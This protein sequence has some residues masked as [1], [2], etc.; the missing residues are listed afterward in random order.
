MLYLRVMAQIGHLRF[1]GSMQNT[2]S[3]APALQPAE[4]S[5]PLRQ[6]VRR[7]KPR[8]RP[9]AV[10]RHRNDSV[11]RA[12]SPAE[13]VSQVVA[14]VLLALARNRAEPWSAA[15]IAHVTKLRVRDVHRVLNLL[16][17]EPGSTDRARRV[18][19][20]RVSDG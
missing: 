7:P 4:G 1:G 18:S 19:V 9:S 12:E 14:K 13:D 5:W 17:S 20:V 2:T 16:A 3:L 11:L 15:E 6:R 10:D 8:A